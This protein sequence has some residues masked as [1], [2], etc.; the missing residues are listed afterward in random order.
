MIARP[1]GRV[2]HPVEGSRTRVDRQA[3]LR[4]RGARRWPPSAL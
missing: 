1:A 2:Y 4:G 3:W